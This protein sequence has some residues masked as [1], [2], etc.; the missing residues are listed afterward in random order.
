[1]GGLGELL[2]TTSFS[3]VFICHRVIL[4]VLCEKLFE[5]LCAARSL[6]AED[7]IS[8]KSPR[9]QIPYGV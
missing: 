4:S 5:I 8:E 1:M 9:W 2:E 3:E 7:A 6:S